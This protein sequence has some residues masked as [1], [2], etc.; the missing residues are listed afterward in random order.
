ME[1][2][3]PVQDKIAINLR[4]LCKVEKSV[5]TEIILKIRGG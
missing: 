5:D 2:K 4:F 3:I 1:G